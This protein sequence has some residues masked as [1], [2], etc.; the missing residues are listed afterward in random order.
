MLEDRLDHRAED[1]SARHYRRHESGEAHVQAELRP[2]RHLLARIETLGRLAD[3][4]PLLRRLQLHAGGGREFLRRRRE[5]AE[6]KSPAAA[7][8]EPVFRSAALRVHFPL[9][10][11]S[12]DQHLARERAGLTVTVELGPGRRRAARHLDPERGV[13]VRGSRRRVLH[14]DLRPVTFQLLGDQDRERGPDALAHFGM[15]EQHGHAFVR[16]D[17]QER[18][19]RGELRR[20]RRRSLLRQRENGTARQ[21]E[22]DE[23]ARSPTG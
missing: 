8:D 12:L 11:R 5:L 22:A 7:N 23:E 2:A 16:P 19:R 3:P 6:G 9:R 10:R 18:I 4:L 21:V 17:A 20:R 13:E 14:V 1:R 15:G